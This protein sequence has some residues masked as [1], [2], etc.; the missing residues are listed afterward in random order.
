MNE[1][2]WLASKNAESMLGFLQQ[3]GKTTDRQLRLFAVACCRWLDGYYQEH[4]NRRLLDDPDREATVQAI[5]DGAD[6]LLGEVGMGL[7]AYKAPDVSRLTLDYVM[8]RDAAMQDAWQAA[9]QVAFRVPRLTWGQGKDVP[10]DR[11]AAQIVREIFGN[12]FRGVQAAPVWRTAE[13]VT[14]AQDIYR[15][16]D[17]ARMP[18]LAAAL[19]RAGCSD[20]SILAHLRSEGPHYRGCW[21]L[22][23]LRTG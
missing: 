22:D 10:G 4:F 7:A 3:N 5:E 16:H 12:P 2:Q 8:I 19:E 1:D 18:E 15:G 23:L 21:V 17:F 6:A 14:L 13:V 20:A 11:A 9:K